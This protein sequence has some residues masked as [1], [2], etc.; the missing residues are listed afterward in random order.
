M[1]VIC[2]FKEA[3]HLHQQGLIPFRLLQDQAMVLLGACPWPGRHIN[4]AVE[5]DS[6]DVERLLTR[7]D[8]SVSYS[9]MLGGN[10]HVCESE[11]DLKEIV[12][13]DME[14]AESHGGRWPDITDQ[15][16]SWDACNYMKESSGDPQWACFLLC[17]NDAGGPVYYVPKHLWQAARVAEHIAATNQAWN[18]EE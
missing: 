17:W 3:H 16:M 5:I 18:A 6:Q 1:I 4:D 14:F 8:V 13:M 12:G 7:P 10:F 11:A 9:D 2:N 15:V